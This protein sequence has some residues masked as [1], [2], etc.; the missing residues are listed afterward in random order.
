M[1]TRIAEAAGRVATISVSLFGNS[2]GGD[3][4]WLRRQQQQQQPPYVN[5]KVERQTDYNPLELFAIANRNRN[6]CVCWQILCQM[7]FNYSIPDHPQ[8]D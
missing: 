6:S 8:F 1:W 4:A 2:G 7:G 5:R 3:E